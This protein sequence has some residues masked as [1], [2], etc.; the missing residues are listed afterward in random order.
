M[1]VAVAV[2]SKDRTAAAIRFDGRREPHLAGAAP[3]LV[4]FVARGLR[5]WRQGAAKLDQ[6]AVAVVPLLQ[7]IEI[8][9]DLVDRRLFH[10]LYIGWTV[11]QVE[12]KRA[13]R[14]AENQALR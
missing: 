2:K 3:H 14:Q 6:I 11:A 12:E 1:G 9:N 13:K 5:Q 4:G 8:L 7:E 10:A